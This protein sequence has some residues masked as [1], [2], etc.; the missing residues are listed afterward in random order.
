MLSSVYSRI[1]S[2][3]IG[4]WHVYYQLFQ[5]HRVWGQLMKTGY[6][7]SR[8]AHQVGVN[9]FNLK[10]IHIMLNDNVCTSLY[11]SLYIWLSLYSIMQ[12]QRFACLYTSQVT[13]LSLYSPD[14]YYR[15]SGDLLPHE[16]DMLGWKSIFAQNFVKYSYLRELLSLLSSKNHGN[17]LMSL[18]LLN[19]PLFSMDVSL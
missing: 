2:I 15:P 11:C 16:N 12:V 6:Q 1:I 18:F 10:L 3:Q 7:S 13:N 8:F 5:F 17:E 19:L 9:S 4:A 14:K